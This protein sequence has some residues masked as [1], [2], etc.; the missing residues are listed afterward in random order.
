MGLPMMPSPMKPIFAMATQLL[1]PLRYK[2]HNRSLDPLNAAF[3]NFLN[4]VRTNTDIAFFKGISN[5]KTRWNN[6][7]FDILRMK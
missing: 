6:L 1:I 2:N 7:P 3:G 4:A 5:I